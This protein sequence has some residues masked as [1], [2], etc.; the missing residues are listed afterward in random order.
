MSYLAESEKIRAGQPNV[1]CLTSSER[2]TDK[3][4]SISC[5]KPGNS[6]QVF[7]KNNKK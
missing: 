3:S 4:H 6:S 5:C 2:N 7:D 1:N